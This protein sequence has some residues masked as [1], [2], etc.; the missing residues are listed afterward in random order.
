MSF[1][2]NSLLDVQRFSM[3]GSRGAYRKTEWLRFVYSARD[4]GQYRP[5][6]W[7]GKGVDVETSDNEMRGT[8]A[9]LAFSVLLMVFSLWRKPPDFGRSA[10]PMPELCVASRLVRQSLLH[11]STRQQIE[12][13]AGGSIVRR[14]VTAR[15]WTA[16][17]A[18]RQDGSPALFS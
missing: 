16:E 9:L 4:A 15:R 2:E 12:Y 14:P 1:G 17:Q 10:S 13:H 6:V 5:M 8:C 11:A 7:F 3:I 18:Y